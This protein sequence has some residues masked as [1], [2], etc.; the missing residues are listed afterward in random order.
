VL[1]VWEMLKIVDDF[2]SSF[3]ETLLSFGI[4]YQPLEVSAILHVLWYAKI[5]GFSHEVEI[6][7]NAS[8]LRRCTAPVHATGQ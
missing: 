5:H 1:S 7:S 2:P 3:H 4:V 8:L 6:C